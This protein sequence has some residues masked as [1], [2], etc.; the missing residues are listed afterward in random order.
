MKKSYYVYAILA[1][2]SIVLLESYSGNNS[3]Y[4]GGSPAG[5]T[6]SPGDGQNCVSCHNGSATSVAG[7]IT[8]DI[9]AEGYTPG[10]TYTITV[11]VSG[12]G[13]KGFEVSPQNASGALLGTLIAGSGNKLVGSGKYV[14]Q[15][16]A[17]SSNP[18]VWTFQWTAPAVGTGD[19]TFYGAFTVSKSVTKLSTLAVNEKNTTGIKENNSGT[20]SM[21]PNPSSG[22]TVISYTISSRNL[23]KIKVYSIAGQLISIPVDEEQTQGNHS[24]VLSGINPGIY[25]VCFDAGGQKSTR[26]L[27]IR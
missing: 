18:K 25:V 21:Y 23:V 17:S 15:S 11:T 22:N 24:F 9:P 12:N 19:V 6:G 4:L 26:K 13:Q 7:W 16:S 8:S 5:Y 2:F 20:F 3:K 14:T 10:T 1:V 27:I